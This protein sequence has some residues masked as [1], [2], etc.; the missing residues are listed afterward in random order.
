MQKIYLP[1]CDFSP[2]WRLTRHFDALELKFATRIHFINGKKIDFPREKL[3]RLRRKYK[4]IT[5][6]TGNFFVCKQ[7]INLT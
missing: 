7:K 6:F 4:K 3:T 5:F 1:A 2:L